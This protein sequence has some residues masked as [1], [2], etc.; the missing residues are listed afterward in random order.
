MA[1]YV[2]VTLEISDRSWMKAYNAGVPAIVR[3]HGGEYIAM[4]R[5]IELIEGEGAPPDAAAI[6]VFPTMEAVKACLG[7]AEYA[8]YRRSR[9]GLA[10][11][12]ILAFES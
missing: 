5:S 4:G 9:I 12:R 11:V 10:D 3:A 8:P 2:V 6:L 7:G 1:V